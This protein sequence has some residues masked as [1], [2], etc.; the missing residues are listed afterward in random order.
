MLTFDF[1]Y[2][3]LQLEKHTPGD[4]VPLEEKN[5]DKKEGENIPA[6]WRGEEFANMI[7]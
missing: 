6:Y 5:K 1:D 3:A 4:V 7:C 2:L